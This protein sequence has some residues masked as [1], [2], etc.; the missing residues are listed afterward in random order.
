MSGR[1]LGWACYV[2]GLVWYVSVVTVLVG[3]DAQGHLKPA[4]PI[5]GA[6]GWTLA[7]LL[8][9]R[10]WRAGGGDEER[11]YDGEGAYQEASA[12]HLRMREMRRADLGQ[13]RDAG[14]QLE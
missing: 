1:A 7:A 6:V 5:A 14:K 10:W 8:A 4:P 13:V 12:R 11:A 2:I 9:R 3:V